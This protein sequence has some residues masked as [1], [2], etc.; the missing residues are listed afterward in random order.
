MNVQNALAAAAA[1]HAAGAHLHDIRQGL[2][3]FHPSFHEAPG[4]LNM[5][6]LHGAKVIID[7]AHNPHSLAMAGDFVQR[8]TSPDG[9]GPAPGRRIAVIASPGDRRDEDMRELGRVAARLFDIV[10][11][12]EDAN[13]RGRQRG[14]IARHVMEGIKGAADSRVKAAEV[15]LDEHPAIQAALTKASPGDV[16]LLCVD[17]PAD[18]WRELEARRAMPVSPAT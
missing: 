11:V 4:R 8:L 14:E 12:R 17:K 16:I 3:S 18:T 1:A 10:I 6:E 7:Y 13:R 5:L 9:N 2:R 15:V